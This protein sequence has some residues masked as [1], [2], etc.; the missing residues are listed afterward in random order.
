[1]K[2]GIT[3]ILSI[4]ILLL[5]TIALAGTAWSFLQ[6]LV[7]SSITKSFIIPQGGSFCTTDASDVNIVKL[8]LRNTGYDDKL[9]FNT[10]QNGGDFIVGEINAIPIPYFEDPATQLGT[11]SEGWTYN[12]PNPGQTEIAVDWDCDDE[13]THGGCPS[14]YNTVDIGTSS[15]IQHLTVYCP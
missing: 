12:A 13:N 4:I 7:F 2:K 5:I 11:P 10:P 1:M 8:Y 14:G 15:T 3:P 6:G 9:I